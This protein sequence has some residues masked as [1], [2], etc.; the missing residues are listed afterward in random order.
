[1]NDILLSMMF[2]DVVSRSLNPHRPPTSLANLTFYE[3]SFKTWKFNEFDHFTKR[4]QQNAD[5]VERSIQDFVNK[6][7]FK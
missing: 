2:M 3:Q 1:M 5:F 6:E 7:M 4:F